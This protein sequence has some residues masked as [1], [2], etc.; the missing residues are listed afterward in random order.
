MRQKNY[1]LESKKTGPSASQVA[2]G[3]ALKTVKRSKGM[4]E[5]TKTFVIEKFNAGAASQNKA[6]PIQVAREMQFAK[7]GTEKPYFTPEE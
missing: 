6:E 7:D 4:D 1:R 3:W 5:K 2:V